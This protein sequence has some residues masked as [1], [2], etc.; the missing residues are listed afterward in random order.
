[1]V[2][3]TSDKDHVAFSNPTS[4]GDIRDSLPLGWKPIPKA[5]ESRPALILALSLAL[6]FFICFFIIGCVFWRKSVIRRRR[7][8]LEAEFKK[9]QPGPSAAEEAKN[10]V[11][12]ETKTKHKIFARATA[13]WK[14]NVRHTARQRKGKRV[15]ASKSSQSSHSRSRLSLSLPS[16]VSSRRSSV[17]SLFDDP[18]QPTISELPPSPSLPPDTISSAMLPPHTNTPV[19]PPAYHHGRV[20]SVIHSDIPRA[21]SFDPQS[22]SA[23]TPFHA[24]H[25]ATDDKGL[26][27]R[28]ADLASRPP[29]D[30][31][32]FD[33]HLSSAPAWHEELEE[34]P[35]SLMTFNDHSSDTSYPSSSL[36]PP[37]PLKERLPTTDFYGP[38]S[39]E[40]MAALEPESEPSAPPFHLCSAPP[41]GDH[42][43][44]P[45]APPLLD[46]ADFL[47]DVHPSAP[48][49]SDS[50]VHQ[51]V[52]DNE[53][54]AGQDHDRVA[55]ASE[56]PSSINV[57]PITFRRDGGNDITL[58]DYRP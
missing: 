28:L 50:T 34:I 23:P 9:H 4:T 33:P 16:R 13:R 26:L 2:V 27:A 10:M 1:M 3:A 40:D 39:Y 15:A 21:T 17:V 25:V 49:W 43:A 38:F 54:P 22:S 46:H 29:E 14:A 51:S 30:T 5:D 11:E 7:R 35:P 36:F 8:D 32:A 52:G 42:E 47:A 55:L 31:L 18:P 57:Q 48:Q 56:L 53:N 44:I 41:L 24:A 12:K 45:S 58:P 37:P 6:A 19:S 20:P